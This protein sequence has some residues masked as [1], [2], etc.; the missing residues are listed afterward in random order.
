MTLGVI[1]GW[2]AWAPIHSPFDD[3]EY[4]ETPQARYPLGVEQVA[5]HH[6]ST[7]KPFESAHKKRSG[8]SSDNIRLEP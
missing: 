5:H 1:I 7:T 2:I 8:L 4:V 3:L 6:V